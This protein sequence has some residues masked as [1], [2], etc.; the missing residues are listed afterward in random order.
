LFVYGGVNFDPYRSIFDKTIGASISSIE[1]YPASEGFI[2]FQ[3][4][5][6]E[7]GML[8]IV[9]SGI[10]YEFIP[11]DD[12]YK[13]IPVRL[14]LENVELEVNY[15][16]I[17]NTNAG[18]WG[19]SIGDIIKFVSIDPYRIVV[20]GR[21]KHFISAFG[22]HVIA[23]E[24]ESAICIAAEKEG[25]DVIE[26]HVAPQVSPINGLPFHE[27]FIEFA[28]EPPDI[29]SMALTIDKLMQEKNIYY[30]TC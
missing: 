10:Y 17:L 22:E 24:V 20:T 16:L 8:L 9:D 2:A 15:A 1:L 21:L 18:L 4:S 6:K 14:S 3:D 29:G 13:E 7:H 30:R 27:W 25:A 28:K 5:Q 19:Y 26:F 11:I 23:E 12:Y